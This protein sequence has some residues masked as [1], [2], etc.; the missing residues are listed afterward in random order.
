MG[1]P[2]KYKHPTWKDGKID[3][4]YEQWKDMKKRCNNSIN[5]RNNSYKDCSISDEFLDYDKYYE[6][7]EKNYYQLENEKICL[8]KD[9]LIKGNK[10]YSPST[11]IFV[12]MR[13]N[14]LFESSK[15]SRG[16]LPKGVTLN[17]NG[18]YVARISKNNKNIFLGSFNSVEEAFNCYK[19]AK[20]NYIKE[21][22]DEYK[23]K[24]PNKLYN[25]M[26]S[27]VIDIND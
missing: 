24:I 19:E 14:Q 5:K 16:L 26:Y 21:I 17:N 22:A 18:R 4:F 8:D 20:E 15:Q 2:N 9:I 12:P 27:Y 7:A 11:C 13:I 3:T 23:S 1:R 10:L 25:A 6:W